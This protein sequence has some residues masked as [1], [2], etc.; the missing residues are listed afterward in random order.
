MAGLSAL[1]ERPATKQDRELFQRYLDLFVQWNR[2]HRMTALGSPAA[3]VREL[4]LD[5][6]LFFPLL[7]ARPLL[8]ADIGAG[9]GAP[10]LPLR[11]A[12]PRIALTL[13]DARRKR[14]SF[15]RAVCRELGLDDVVVREGRA[16][17]LV[18]E[19]PGVAASFDVVVTRAAGPVQT[20]VPTV[21]QYLKDDGILVAAASPRAAAGEGLELVRVPVPGGRATRSFL[22]G[23]RK[24]NVPRGT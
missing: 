8:V 13:I 16:E 4:F 9:S 5:S 24:G 17:D 7:P 3:I 20:L 15:L 18:Q 21:M 11:I 22:K 2:V 19:G 12:D 23:R 1:V 14:V 10:G 6:L